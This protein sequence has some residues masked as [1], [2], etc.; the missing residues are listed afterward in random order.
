MLHNLWKMLRNYWFQS[1]LVLEQ[2][3]FTFEKALRLPL[4]KFPE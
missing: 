2:N 1:R 4:I 3:Q